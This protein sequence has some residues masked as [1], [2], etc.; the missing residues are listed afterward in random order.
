MYIWINRNICIYKETRLALAY[1]F[2]ELEA[3]KAKER[4][5][6]NLK[7]FLEAENVETED[8][9][10]EKT[11]DIIAQKAGVSTKTAEQ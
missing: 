7:Q 8:I 3:E 4:K 9:I 5:L 10:K 2:K 6:A 1:R 11:L